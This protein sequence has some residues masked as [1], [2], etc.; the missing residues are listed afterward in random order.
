MDGKMDGRMDGRMVGVVGVAGIHVHKKVM[1]GK[2]NGIKIGKMFGMM[3]GKVDGRVDGNKDGM[4]NLMDTQKILG[5]IQINGAV[6]MGLN[7]MDGR[8]EGKVG[9]N[10]KQEIEMNREDLMGRMGHL[11]GPNNRVIKID[12]DLMDGINNNKDGEMDLIDLEAQK[13][14]MD[15]MDGLKI[16]EIKMDLID[17][18]N[19]NNKTIKMDSK[20]QMG[21]K[22]LK[23]QMVPMVG[24]APTAGL[25]N[26]HNNNK[27]EM[28]HKDHKDLK[29]KL[30]LKVGEDQMV[31]L[32][33]IK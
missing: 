6:V 3:H 32:N 22:V 27:V 2:I 28:G 20:G 14:L 25:N 5:V 21:L 23:E 29:D 11:G 10:N 26:N 12:G 4:E 9:L 33:E 15:L 24:V 17:G 16:K 31:G 8:M 1:D 18:H 13:D 7:N 19:G 30:D